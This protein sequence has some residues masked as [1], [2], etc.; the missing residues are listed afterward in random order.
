MIGMA[1][2]TKLFNSILAS[3]V[4]QES[5]STKV[6]WIT[7]L[8]MADKDGVAEAS[9]PGLAKIAGLSITDT[10]A[11]IKSLSAPDKYSRTRDFDG[12]R[13]EACDGGWRILNHAKYRQ[14]MS[15]DD[16]REY[17]RTKQQEYRAA[18]KS[19][20]STG[21][22]SG[23]NAEAKAEAY[24]KAGNGDI[25]PARPE[26][27]HEACNRFTKDDPDIPAI[28]RLDEDLAFEE[29]RFRDLAIAAGRD[30]I[31]A[32]LDS[33]PRPATRA[34][35]SASR[36]LAT[37]RTGIPRDERALTALRLTCD[38]LEARAR[39]QGAVHLSDSNRET[40]ENI[41]RVGER[42]KAKEAQTNKPKEITG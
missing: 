41:R 10:E 18:S 34:P 8:A 22:Q 42:M 3:S 4:W 23:H 27:I 35:F 37:G 29:I 24:S 9:V 1:G 38:A 32:V 7:F 12:R 19:T 5:V 16:R 33:L 20:K 31:Q 15:A 17:K 26:T 14:K 39:A 30:N 6:L 36:W 13:I 11:G 21:G 25:A 40:L 28:D 2:Y